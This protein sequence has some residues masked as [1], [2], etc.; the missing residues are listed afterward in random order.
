[1]KLSYRCLPSMKNFVNAHNQK[2]LNN[3]NTTPKELRLQKAKQLPIQWRMFIEWNLQSDLSRK[4][5]KNM[6][7]QL[8]S[9]LRDDITTINIT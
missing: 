6:W 5:T 1:M 4:G 7:V 8:T 9:L 3:K 2:K